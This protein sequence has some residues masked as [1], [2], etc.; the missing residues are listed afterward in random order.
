[1]KKRTMMAAFLSVSMLTGSV[2]SFPILA[3]E[4]AV[5]NETTDAAQSTTTIYDHARNT[6]Y[7]MGTGM[8]V[9]T[10]TNEGK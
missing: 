10:V 8:Q 1:M 3:A 5:Q 7:P 2:S 6:W 4:P 9:E